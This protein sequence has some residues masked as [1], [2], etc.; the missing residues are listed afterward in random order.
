[1]MTMT[2][3]EEAGKRRREE[4]RKR[5]QPERDIWYCYMLTFALSLSKV[6]MYRHRAHMHIQPTHDAWRITHF[7]PSPR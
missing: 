4:G 1:M 7:Q 5:G 3:K 6:I 2:R